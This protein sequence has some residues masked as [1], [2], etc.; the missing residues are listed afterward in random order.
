MTLESLLKTIHKLQLQAQ[1]SLYECM[2]SLQ[3]SICRGWSWYWNTHLAVEMKPPTRTSGVKSSSGGIPHNTVQACTGPTDQVTMVIDPLCPPARTSWNEL[4]LP[5]QLSLFLLRLLTLLSCFVLFSLILSLRIAFIVYMCYLVKLF[6]VNETADFFRYK[7]CFS[8]LFSRSSSLSAS[9]SVW[10]SDVLMCVCVCACAQV[11]AFSVNTNRHEETVSASWA[12]VEKGIWGC[13]MLQQHG[14]LDCWAT[15]CQTP[16]LTV[17]LKASDWAA[18]RSIMC[19]VFMCCVQSSLGKICL[20]GWKT[21][22]LLIFVI[23]FQHICPT[24]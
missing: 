12:P 1:Y 15:F 7:L 9:F 22:C 10:S 23:M 21:V 18:L 8:S 19:S 5:R 14:S 16:H 24:R 17:L 2:T 4:K 3:T 6:Y 13:Y 20:V 11:C